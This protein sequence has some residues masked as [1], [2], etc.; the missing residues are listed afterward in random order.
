MKTAS[1]LPGGTP[2][3]GLFGSGFS[4]VHAPERAARQ[5]ERAPA[6]EPLGKSAAKP[7]PYPPDGFNVLGAVGVEFNFI[8][9]VF[10]VHRDRG[11]IS[12]GIHPPDAVK[13]TVLGKHGVRM[14]SQKR[15]RSYSLLVMLVSLPL[16]QTRRLSRSIS[17]PRTFSISGRAFSRLPTKR[18]YR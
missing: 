1:P 2:G 12:I 7:V 9:D 3:R 4:S 10:D 13:Q 5:K 18:W 8:P 6:K 11:D 17:S 15:S 14:L 16:T